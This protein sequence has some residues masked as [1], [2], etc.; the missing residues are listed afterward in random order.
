M[1]YLKLKDDEKNVEKKSLDAMRDSNGISGGAHG[2]RQGGSRSRGRLG[3]RLYLAWTR[4][5][6]RQCPACPVHRL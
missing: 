4:L 3:E 1:C 6:K 5:G 2:T